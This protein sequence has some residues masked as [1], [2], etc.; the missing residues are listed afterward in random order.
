MWSVKIQQ[1]FDTLLVNLGMEPE[2]VSTTDRWIMLLVIVLLAVLMDLM[3]RFILLKVVR[4]IVSRTKAKW[5]DII[6]DS[7]VMRRLCN[8]VTPILIYV[9]LPIAFPEQSETTSHLNKLLSR[10]I[11]IY[12]IIAVVRFINSFLR[13]VFELAERKPEWHGRPIKGFMQT[14]QVIVVCVAVI[15]IISILIDRSPAILL[16][17]LGASAAIMSLIFKDS[18]LGLVAGAQLSVNNMLKVG[19][20]IAMPSRGVDGVVEEVALTVVKVRNWDMTLQ[21]LPPYL[22]ISEPFSNWH[23]MF[24][25]G[26][27]RTRRS[28]NIDMTSVRF[29]SSSEIGELSKN[30]FVGELVESIAST[31]RE[32]TTLTNLDIFMRYMMQY[33]RNH[34]RVNS[35][36]TLLVR[37]LQPTEWGLP[38]EFYYFSAST[39]WAEYEELQ[40]EVISHAVALAPLF[41]LSLFQL[42]VPAKKSR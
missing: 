26:G 3:F 10:I 12:M 27:R 7:N 15:L 31:D 1:W 16:T 29:I 5:D 24:E 37:Q 28:I 42:E 36:M 17:G 9:L 34:P 38:V 21:M 19:D 32:G 25:S 40:S 14:G 11:E 8:I 4:N 6:F 20:W 18:I 33:L 22:L 41:D 35:Q 2:V 13:A 23:A 39:V 30:E